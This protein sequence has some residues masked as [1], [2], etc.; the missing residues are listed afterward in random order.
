[1][2]GGGGPASGGQT[3]RVGEAARASVTAA[4]AGALPYIGGWVWDTEG[5]VGRVSGGWVA[6][7]GK[8]GGKGGVA[9]AMG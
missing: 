7:V 6:G 2:T 9:D 1:M 3:G 4:S 8:K 5:R